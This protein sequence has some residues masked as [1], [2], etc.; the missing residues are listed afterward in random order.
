MNIDNMTPK[1]R[2]LY[3]TLLQYDTTADLIRD[4]AQV[5]YTFADMPA[6][7]TEM[8]ALEMAHADKMA[9]L[10]GACADRV[11]ELEER[12]LTCADQ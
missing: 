2:A 3:D 11:W 5:V 12:H 7:L 10:L 6:H 8:C 9:H 1:M 4:L